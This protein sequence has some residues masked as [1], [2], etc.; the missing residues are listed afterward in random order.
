MH[1]QVSEHTRTKGM[2]RRTFSHLLVLPFI[3]RPLFLPRLL[4]T[5]TAGYNEGDKHRSEAAEGDDIHTKLQSCIINTATKV[6]PAGQG[7]NRGHIV[8]VLA[9][10]NSQDVT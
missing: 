4:P 10:V 9:H 5:V 2:R 1:L 8:G 7:L 6:I 3:P